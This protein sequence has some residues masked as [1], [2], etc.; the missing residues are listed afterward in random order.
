MVKFGVTI[1][2]APYDE[3]SKH[4]RL[5]EF[6]GFDSVWIPDHIVLESY[7]SVCPE[8]WSVLSAFATLTK[9]VTLGTAVTDPYRRHP[10]VLAQTVATLDQ[11]S[12]GRAILGLGAGEAMN[13]GPFGILRDRRL[14]RMKET[15]EILRMLWAGEIINYRGKVFDLSHAFIQVPSVQKPWP[16]IYLA[17]NSPKTRRLVGRYGD[18]WLAEMMSPEKYVADRIEVEDSARNAGRRIED[19][20]ITYVVTTAVSSDYEKARKNAFFYA[21]RKF[22]WWPKQL[23][24]YGYDITDE[25]DWNFLTVERETGEKIDEHVSEVP[26]EPCEEVTIFGDPDDCIEKISKYLESGVTHFQ[27][28][29]A[30]QFEEGLRLM[31]NK[32]LPYFKEQNW[33]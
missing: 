16:P 30:D 33:D 19:I 4:V 7:E 31:Q 11:I 5:A 28:E 10:A 18:G 3:M 15:I 23:E 6:L 9:R 12:G 1:Q 21:K 2:P 24:R 20:D 14:A 32:I 17:A 26:D 27:F 22:L 29:I 25:F 13:V 8:T